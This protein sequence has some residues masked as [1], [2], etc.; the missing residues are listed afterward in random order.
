[1]FTLSNVSIKEVPALN[2]IL[3]IAE[4]D[5]HLTGYVMPESER[6]RI[7]VSL[8]NSGQIVGFFTPRYEN[9]KW[10]IGATYFYPEF[11]SKTLGFSLASI[12]INKYFKGKQL[13]EVVDSNNRNAKKLLQKCNMTLTLALSPE[14]ELW[15]SITNNAGGDNVQ[16]FPSV[17]ED[18]LSSSLKLVEKW[19]FT[20][21]KEKL[22]EPGYAGWSPERIKKAEE[23]YKR[24]LALT[25][26]LNGYQPVPNGDIDRFWHEHIL[27]TKRYA[28]DCNE[29]FG[30]FLH[31]YPFFGMR[32]EQ[33]NTAWLQASDFS[34]SLWSTQFGENLYKP[35]TDVLNTY[36]ISNPI[37]EDNDMAVTVS[38]TI[39]V[40][41]AGVTGVGVAES[42]SA[43][44]MKCPQA[45]PN[46]GTGLMDTLATEAM[47]CPQACPNPGTGIAGVS[48]DTAMKCPQACPNPGTGIT[49]ASD[50][51]ASKCPQACPSPGTGIT[52]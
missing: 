25:K 3:A 18:I 50:D 20:L 44:A 16:Q 34:N 4:Q 40:N 23:N 45:C 52:G 14:T 36:S 5:S 47:K 11:R 6:R 12:A 7:V 30:Y 42:Q 26:A 31:H 38:I 2:K 15:E 8:S 24:Y 21:T 33:D 41:G 13:H 28:E 17:N 32:G 10:R 49:G 19:D 51:T 29:L 9:K 35:K 1:M 37:L 22:L 48:D 27:D 39:N 43:L 46:P